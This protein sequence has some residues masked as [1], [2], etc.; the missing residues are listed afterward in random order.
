MA[1][2]HRG[3]QGSYI[4]YIHKVSVQGNRAAIEVIPRPAGEGAR[5]CSGARTDFQRLNCLHRSHAIWTSAVVCHVNNWGRMET[6]RVI[7]STIV[8]GYSDFGPTDQTVTRGFAYP[9][10]HLSN[11]RIGTYRSQAVAQ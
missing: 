2:T 1:A 5:R 9:T 11:C 10:I 3:Q 6:R 4:G 7:A 8:G